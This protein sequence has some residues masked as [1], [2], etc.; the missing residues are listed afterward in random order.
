MPNMSID[1]DVYC[2]VCGEGLCNCTKVYQTKI[3]IKPCPRCIE[4]AKD[5]GYREGYDEGYQEGFK[6][7]Y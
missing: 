4:K 6:T 2:A 1:F 5:E 7:E 3:I